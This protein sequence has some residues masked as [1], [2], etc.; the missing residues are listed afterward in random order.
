[1]GHEHDLLVRMPRQQVARSADYTIGHSPEVF[2]ARKLNFGRILHPLTVEIGI[3][4]GDL[5]VWAPFEIAEVQLAKRIYRLDRAGTAGGDVARG[6]DTALSGARV[7]GIET[8]A[9]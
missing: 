3:A 8:L 5:I 9:R 6:L 7:N 1:M 2:T 4:F